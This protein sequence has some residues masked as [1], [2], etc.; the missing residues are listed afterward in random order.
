MSQKRA[1]KTNEQSI[2]P[3]RIQQMLKTAHRRG[4]NSKATARYINDSKTAANLGV[5]FT[6]RQIQ[7]TLGNLTRGHCY[8][9]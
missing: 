3:K 1:R 8:W 4:M 7:T 6:A 5:E 9:A 2:Y